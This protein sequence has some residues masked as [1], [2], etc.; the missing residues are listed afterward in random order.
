MSISIQ[1]YVSMY[2]VILV[3]IFFVPFRLL[4]VSLL[5]DCS[6]Y[7]SSPHTGVSMISLILLYIFS[8][9]MFQYIFMSP[10]SI[11][12]HNPI[13]LCFGQYHTA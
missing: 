1:F 11:Y 10:V 8:F 7:V 3:Y 5:S 2:Y 9:L 4:Y 6:M 12:V 13:T